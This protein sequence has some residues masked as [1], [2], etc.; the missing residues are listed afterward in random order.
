MFRHNNIPLNQTICQADSVLYYKIYIRI[1]NCDTVCS[2]CTRLSTRLEIRNF[3]SPIASDE[4]CFDLPWHISFLSV[5]L[6]LTVKLSLL[7]YDDTI[8]SRSSLNRFVILGTA[9]RTSSHLNVTL[10]FLFSC[11]ILQFTPSLWSE[12]NGTAPL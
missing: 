2:G 8:F 7:N 12:Q 1:S 11:S 6:S 3:H 10:L 4:Q 5:Y 9:C